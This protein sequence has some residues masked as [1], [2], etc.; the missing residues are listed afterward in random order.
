MSRAAIV[1]HSFADRPECYIALVPLVNKSKESGTRLQKK[2]GEGG[3]ETNR[4]SA[5]IG[6]V[7]HG[8][9]QLLDVRQVDL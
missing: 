7:A 1:L 6:R 3:G 2:G 4:S 9:L 5:C 8:G